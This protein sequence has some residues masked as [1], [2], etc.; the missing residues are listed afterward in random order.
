MQVVYCEELAVF[1]GQSFVLLEH[2]S[3]STF[4]VTPSAVNFWKLAPIDGPWRKWRSRA[5]AGVRRR[6]ARN[7]PGSERRRS[8]VYGTSGRGVEI[9]E[10][11]VPN[12]ICIAG[13]VL[14]EHEFCVQPSPLHRA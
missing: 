9:K 5:A 1:G 4:A 6:R 11:E 13:Y 14:Y 3:S 10:D 2:T 7:L 12:N 8:V